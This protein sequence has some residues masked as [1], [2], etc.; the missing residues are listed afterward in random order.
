MT[1]PTTDKE[2]KN[3]GTRRI[4]NVKMADFPDADAIVRQGLSA[5]PRT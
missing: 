1:T 4:A 5:V 3:L 2:W